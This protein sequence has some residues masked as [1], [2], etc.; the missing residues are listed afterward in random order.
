MLE[1]ARHHYWTFY[2]RF[3]SRPGVLN[4]I[5]FAPFRFIYLAHRSIVFLIKL[6]VRCVEFIFNIRLPRIKLNLSW[7]PTWSKPWKSIKVVRVVTR[8]GSRETRPWNRSRIVRVCTAAYRMSFTKASRCG[9]LTN[10]V[11]SSI[12]AFEELRYCHSLG[13]VVRINEPL[14]QRLLRNYFVLINQIYRQNPILT[15]VDDIFLFLY[16]DP[17]VQ[18]NDYSDLFSL[19]CVL[20]RCGNMGIYLDEDSLLETLNLHLSN[21]DFEKFEAGENIFDLSSVDEQ[22]VRAT[23]EN[24]FLCA[25]LL[26]PHVRKAGNDFL[27]TMGREKVTIALSLPEDLPGHLSVE[28]FN[29]WLPLLERVHQ[30]QPW[31]AFFLLNRLDKPLQQTLPPYLITVYAHGM[32]LVST[33][34]IAQQADAYFGVLD[35]KG[36]AANAGRR[37][38]VF[39]PLVQDP[40][41]KRETVASL[42]SDG[43]HRLTYFPEMDECEELLLDLAQYLY[44]RSNFHPSLASGF[45]QENEAE[46]E[47]PQQLQTKTS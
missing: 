33:I 21:K 10:Y 1:R 27:K 14:D 12:I 9:R 19:S 30:Q 3:A 46:T 18:Q 13:H 32:D 36:F 22:D 26:E 4:K 16:V 17:A 45:A 38:G 23:E 24:E 35:C 40:R 29:Q 34:C 6:P 7:K 25:Y 20:E 5:C 37:P 2:H 31:T 39:L 11:S 15:P 41:A 47:K 43:K 28:S 8:A 44:Q 42:V